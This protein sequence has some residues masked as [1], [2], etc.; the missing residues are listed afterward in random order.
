MRAILLLLALAAPA[1]GRGTAP[2]PS[3]SSNQ[4]VS[5]TERALTA[6]TPLLAHVPMGADVVLEADIR[7]LRENP[8]VSPLISA[9]A[10]RGDVRV[11]GGLTFN[12]VR[13]ADVLVVAAYQVGSLGARAMFLLGGERMDAGA[14]AA[15]EVD[16]T[17]VGRHEV[18]FGPEPLRQEVFA[19]VQGEGRGSTMADD[20][21]FL[22]IR[23]LA[24]PARAEGASVRLTARLSKEARI[25][26]AGQLGID[27]APRDISAWVD[28][29]DDLA[30]VA[31]LAS[32]DSVGADR[33]VTMVLGARDSWSKRFPPLARLSAERKG[34][35][36]RVAWVLPPRRFSALASAL[37]KELR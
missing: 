21:E 22:R 28:V 37:A 16:A 13:D 35:G 32:D 15:A 8:V 14:V 29:A 25:A 5:L 9:L 6:A 1:C 3:T 17:A 27:E 12:P 24:M 30:A 26:T 23:D 20:Q 11:P 7:R 34:R 31:L 33:A 19:R 18:V 36:V 10:T 4:A 2:P